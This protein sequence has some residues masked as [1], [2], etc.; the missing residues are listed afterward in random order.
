MVAAVERLAA[1]GRLA[2]VER[3]FLRLAVSAIGITR[4]GVWIWS[5]AQKPSR[6]GLATLPA[7]D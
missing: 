6:P 3:S 7:V 2:A 5:L 4:G 1:G